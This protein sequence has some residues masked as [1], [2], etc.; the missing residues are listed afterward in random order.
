LVGQH[1]T[2]T[3][4]GGFSASV[5]VRLLQLYLITT[6]TK[7]LLQINFAGM[8]FDMQAAVNNMHLGAVA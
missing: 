2:A 7:G 6:K 5:A 1:G 3:T 4:G 8:V